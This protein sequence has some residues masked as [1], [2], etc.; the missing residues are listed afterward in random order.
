MIV[1]KEVTMTPSAR[2]NF[3]RNHSPKRKHTN[4]K[5]NGVFKFKKIQK[6]QFFFF[7]FNVF[8]VNFQQAAVLL[9]Q[10]PD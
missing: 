1:L 10:N 7:K 9:I 4:G 3:T 2:Q 6:I 5:V 8:N